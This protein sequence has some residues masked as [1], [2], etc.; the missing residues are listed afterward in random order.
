[1]FGQELVLDSFQM[2]GIFTESSF[3]LSYFFLFASYFCFCLFLMVMLCSCILVD[4]PD[5]RFLTTRA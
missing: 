4:L 2:I 1:M 5:V 3:L